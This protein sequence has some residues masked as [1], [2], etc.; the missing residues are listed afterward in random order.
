M[1]HQLLRLGPWTSMI[2]LTTIANSRLERFCNWDMLILGFSLWLILTLISWYQGASHSYDLRIP[3]FYF[4]NKMCIPVDIIW[5]VFITNG[6]ISLEPLSY[7]EFFFLS[8]LLIV[9]QLSCYY[10]SESFLPVIVFWS[11]IIG[12]VMM[13]LNFRFYVTTNFSLFYCP[14]EFSKDMFGSMIKS[15][16]WVWK[17]KFH[18]VFLFLRNECATWN[19]LLNISFLFLIFLWRKS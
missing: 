7:G 14:F 9:L 2:R 16:W 13:S 1:D 5:A 10:Y 4:D 3:L 15:D 17:I 18:L 6:S 12:K 11:C 8:I 19:I